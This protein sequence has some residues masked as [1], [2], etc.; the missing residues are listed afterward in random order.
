MGTVRA[1]VRHVVDVPRIHVLQSRSPRHVIRLE[2]RAVRR[3]RPVAHPEVGVE[4]REVQRHLVAAMAENPVA[5]AANVVHRVVG[6]GDDQV[7]DLEP[8]V[9]LVL[10]PGERVEHRLQMRIGDVVIELLGEPLQIDVRRI[11]HLE[12]RL[13]RFGG[14][15]A[16]GDGHGLDPDR[17]AGP[18][19][20]DGVFGPD[21]RVVVGEG[22]APAAMLL[23][24]RGDGL[25]RG[26]LA[27]P[28]DLAR[29]R[30]IPVLAEL[31]AQIAAGGAERQ[32]ACAR[33]ELIQRLLFDRVDTEPRASSIGGEHHLAAQ[34]LPHETEA[35]IP[36]LQATGPRAEVADDPPT[37]GGVV[38]PAPRKRAVSPQAAR[39]WC[40]NLP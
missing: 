13:P 18:R 23:R 21:Y 19:G 12:E 5:H 33:I 37:L 29:L 28:L 27:Q 40:G 39:R 36:R 20:V 16:R 15:V 9:R 32:N 11:H 2:Q 1:L 4:R 10:E 6:L 30:D 7:S 38:P 31:T 34:V 8:D 14:N 17:M 24:C 25:G 26:D 22:D 35:A 3:V